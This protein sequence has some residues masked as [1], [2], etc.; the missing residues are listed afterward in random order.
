MLNLSVFF[1]VPWHNGLTEPDYWYEFM[2]Q[3]NTAMW[4][5]LAATKILQCSFWG[6]FKSLQNWPT[7][8][9]CMCFL[10]GVYATATCFYYVLWTQYYSYYTPMPFT[11]YIC[12]LTAVI[13][14]YIVLY[15][16]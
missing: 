1:F 5:T 12:G 4:P 9:T 11:G 10:I 14:I 6:N 7:F 3:V 2:I 16:R 13:V 15:W 8:I